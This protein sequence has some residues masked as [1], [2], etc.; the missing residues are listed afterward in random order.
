MQYTDF[1]FVEVFDTIRNEIDEI[2]K[3]KEKVPEQV[4]LKA[5]L[6]F[7]QAVKTRNPFY[8]DKAVGLCS[9]YQ[10]NLTPTMQK[11]V[12]ATAVARIGGSPSGTFG[13]IQRNGRNEAVATWMAHL[14]AAGNGIQEASEKAASLYEINFPKEKPKPASSISK[15]YEEH[16]R[17]LCVLG[18]P[19]QQVI[20]EMH[21]SDE[22]LR[23]SWQ[24]ISR[25]TPR[26][27]LHKGER[28]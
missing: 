12:A 25:N 26:T 13:Q 16:F 1:D 14:V 10:F 4:F 24:L 22:R 2:L 23:L 11:I 3:R 5:P 20:N 17:N 6:L 21:E 8:A 19:N 15:F 9:L 7:S 27:E 18:R 28:R